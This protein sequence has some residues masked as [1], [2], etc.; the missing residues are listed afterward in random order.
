MLGELRRLGVELYS[1]VEVTA[2]V[3]REHD[4][5]AVVMALGADPIIP[6]IPGSTEPFVHDAQSL[7]LGQRLV[8]DG[9]RV[10]VI[11]AAATG[12]ETAEHL[13]AGG[14][15]V[16]LV[17]QLPTLGAGIE[18]VTRD[19]IVGWLLARG[20]E[21]LSSTTV[22]AIEPGLVRC[23]GA[24]GAQRQIAADIVALAVGFRPRGAALAEALADY[25]LHMVGDARNAGDFVHAVN[26]A[27]D[28]ALAI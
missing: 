3:V 2:D 27:A 4:P 17:E 20:T 1:G 28:A 11:G 7:L 13:V 25:E 16:T 26:T 6:P 12:L 18:M 10:V 24:D 15:V 9:A 21:I 19:H 23:Q 22:V 14:A 8:Q 5:D